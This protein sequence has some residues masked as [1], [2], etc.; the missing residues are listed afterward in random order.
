MLWLLVHR[1]PY[2]ASSTCCARPVLY[3][4]T[5]GRTWYFMFVNGSPS[6]H[7][8]CKNNDYRKLCRTTIDNETK[9]ERHNDDHAPTVLEWRVFGPMEEIL[10]TPVSGTTTACLKYV[11]DLCSTYAKQ[12]NILNFSMQAASFSEARG[13]ASM[14][15]Y[16]ERTL[17]E[18]KI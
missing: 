17:L 1:D 9:H 10:A 5:P 18:C 11:S 16:W 4:C 2:I 12:R 3:V 8:C 7:H 14:E 15:L 6:K 13:T